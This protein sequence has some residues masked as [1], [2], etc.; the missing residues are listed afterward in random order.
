MR[1]I[2]FRG[3]K[4]NNEWV[5]GSL[6]TD[7]RE[8]VDGEIFDIAFITANYP[9]KDESKEMWVSKMKRVRVDTIGQFTGLQD[10]N[11]TD[12]YEGDILKTRVNDEP[13]GIVQWHTDGYFF[14]NADKDQHRALHGSQ[15]STLG[16]MLAVTLS[17]KSIELEVIGNIYDN[18]AMKR[19]ILNK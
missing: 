2:K 5:Y 12:I 11:G 19:K 7:K 6:I 4:F 1:T 16:Y 8:G 13:F 3:K 10:K 14:I 17:G 15:Y 18:P 9:R